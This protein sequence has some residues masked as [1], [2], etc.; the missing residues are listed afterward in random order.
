[1]G[2]EEESVTLVSKIGDK[3]ELG[4]NVN[5]LKNTMHNTWLPC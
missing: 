2:M 5:D 3:M 4:C 1:M